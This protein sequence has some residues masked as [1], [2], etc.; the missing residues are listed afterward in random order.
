MCTRRLGTLTVTVPGT[1]VPSP[2]G[3]LTSPS[4]SPL[5]A[6][7]VPARRRYVATRRLGHHGVVDTQSP[8]PVVMPQPVEAAAH[9]P[10]PQQA[11]AHME[12]PPPA[13]PPAPP[14]PPPPP[15]QAPPPPTSP[16][17]PTS[18]TPPPR[19]QGYSLLDKA[20]RN[21][22]DHNNP[23]N[24]LEYMEV[25]D[26]TAQAIML[27]SDRWFADRVP[28]LAAPRDATQPRPGVLDRIKLVQELLASGTA[29]REFGAESAAVKLH[30][31]AATGRG[32]R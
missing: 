12:S 16:S 25:A 14:P 11:A 8:P 19:R 21:L 4:P 27:V 17:P 2:Q 31:V 26:M 10:A 6:D 20:M 32:P 30:A 29:P 5:E 7:H 3:P 23:P 15:P 1:P 13:P 24:S 28:T 9:V 18:A 22:G